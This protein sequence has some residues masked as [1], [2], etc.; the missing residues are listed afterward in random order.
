MYCKGCKNPLPKKAESS[1]FCVYCGR[2]VGGVP[3]LVKTAPPLAMLG[4]LVAVM[5]ILFRPDPG[6]DL[7]IQDITYSPASP[8]AG[9]NVDINVSVKNKGNRDAEASITCCYVDETSVG[10][11]ETD[12]IPAGTTVSLKF[13]WTAR[14][15]SHTVKVA[16]DCDSTVA[17]RSEGNNSKEVLI[18]V[19][20]T[21][22]PGST[23]L[24][25]NANVD[26]FSVY[27]DQ[28][29]ADTPASSTATIGELSAGTHALK[30]T[31]PGYL[32]WTK[33]VG[34]TAGQTTTVYAYLETG[35]GS[36]TTRNEIVTASSTSGTLKVNTG[37]NGVRIDVGGEFGGTT[38]D[39][40]GGT[41]NGLFEGTYT[42]KLTMPGYKEWAKQVGITTG[43]ATTVYAYLETGEG[44]ATTRS[45][46]ITASSTS[47]TLKVNT[48]LD[49]VRIDIG[50]EFGGTTDDQR[51]GTV[52]G[53]FEGT[54]TLKL[55]MPGYKDWAKQVAIT[56]GQTTTVYAYLETGEGSAT[57]RSETITPST[58]WGTLSVDTDQ[59]GVDIW[60]VD[61]SRACEY[62]GGVDSSG[63]NGNIK[64]PAGDYTLKLTK[65]EFRNWSKQVSIVADQTTAVYAYIEVGSGD[66]FTRSETMTP[67]TA[68]GTLSVDTNQTGVAIWIGETSQGYEY[69]GG[70]DSSGNN[71]NISIPAGT[72]TLRLA[73]TEFKNWSKQVSIASGA[74]TTVY[75]YLEVG[76]GDA[77]TRSETIT[78]NTA[79]GTLSI[80]TDQTGVAIWIGETSK[81]Y[82]YGGG[83][84][85]NGNNGNIKIPAGT[86]TL[87][88][89]KTEFKNWSKQVSIA[90]GATTT[91]Y[92]YLEVG[93]GDAFT[94]SETITP[95]TGWGTLSLNTNVS[96]VRIWVGDDSL[97]YEF[98]GLGNS[99]GDA[100]VKLPAGTYTLKLTV[101]GYQEWK[102][103][104]TITGGGTTTVNITLV[105][106]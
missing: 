61:A 73:K 40:R 38:D 75:A 11:S 36:A 4:V 65:T 14:S 17:E 89:T 19:L 10:S 76:S 87:R 88:F 30:L 29:L 13:R 94:R 52:N 85:S 43:Q 92:A 12:P 95:N 55:T 28:A 45:E 39:Y 77:F 26:A 54:Y 27:V 59:T 58:A 32:D 68:W 102:G 99:S 41:V 49:G 15:G 37:L 71:G 80:N 104:I 70:V 67:S 81:G 6:P 3:T 9:Q 93:S 106:L 105:A 79:W 53:L 35:E 34:I 82:E 72:Y 83:V 21:P 46:T 66:A 16:A 42:L 91:V 90:S 78:P 33:Q 56:T 62:G 7:A 20:G 44:S 5:V 18:S 60:I 50:G 103:Q 74:K 1:K 63:N 47:G 97:G 23:V 8:S 98:G 101:S 2:P 64:I 69:G 25:V 84:D 24:K 86:Y 48:G 31:K 96:G 22:G 51:G 100:T 57:A